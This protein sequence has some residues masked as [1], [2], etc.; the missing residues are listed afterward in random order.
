MEPPLL[1]AR[2]YFDPRPE[3]SLDE[4]LTAE[5]PGA[6]VIG[7]EREYR[8]VSDGRA[9]DFREVLPALGLVSGGLDPVDPR[10]HHLASGLVITADGP[11][12]EVASPPV[13]LAPGSTWLASSWVEDGEDLLI[14]ALPI[15]SGLEGYSTHLNVSVR[16]DVV[17]VAA[18]FAAHF[19]LGMMLLLDR[20]DS[21]GLLVRPRPGRLEL[22]GDFVAGE[23][24]RAALTYATA[25]ARCCEQAVH[26]RGSV[27]P[28]SPRVRLRTVTDRPGWFIERTAFGPDLYKGGRGASIWCGRREVLAGEHLEASWI[29]A[30]YA[31]AGVA[32]ESEL[33]LVDDVV[34]GRR[35]IPLEALTPPDPR[36]GPIATESPFAQLHARHRNGTSV[37]VA[38][39]S[40]AAVAFAV[41][42][43]TSTVHVLVPRR[44]LRSFLT[45]LDGDWLDDGTLASA[46]SASPPSNPRAGGPQ[47]ITHGFDPHCVVPPEPRVRTSF[48]RHRRPEL[49]GLAAGSGAALAV[50]G[51]RAW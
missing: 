5:P 11:E 10:A 2:P 32:D 45:G 43:G 14:G 25:A 41:D 36:P 44:W 8:V 28:S 4:L 15:G 34:D 47:V 39:I 35:P 50:L 38:A 3:M 48:W 27:L 26:E 9:V 37:T 6:G 31:A 22:G 33:A 21:P 40:W 17:E 23:Q 51:L 29:A 42:T 1:L 30:R 16:G 12:A 13:L 7:V 20:R 19:S 24:L 46:L 49:I 18:R